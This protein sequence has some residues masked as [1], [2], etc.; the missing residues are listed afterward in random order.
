[1]NI[2]L[3]GTPPDAAPDLEKL[4]AIK[5]WVRALFRLDDTALVLV[6]EL[7]CKD[8][9]C[10]DIETSIVVSLAPKE[11]L[12][13]SIPKRAADVSQ[14]DVIRELSQPRPH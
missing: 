4:K 1:M 14:A 13:F 12:T 6:N 10:A 5:E 3:L 7:A 11:Y 2:N 8:P 9:D